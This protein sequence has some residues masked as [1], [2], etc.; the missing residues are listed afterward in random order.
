MQGIGGPGTLETKL[1]REVAARHGIVCPYAAD[2]HAEWNHCQ[3]TRIKIIL[4]D[5]PLRE[6]ITA[7]GP[8]SLEDMF[9]VG[10]ALIEDV[11]ST[12]AFAA[13]DLS[14]LAIAAAEEINAIR[15]GQRMVAINVKILTN[16]PE[17]KSKEPSL[18]AMRARGK[19]KTGKYGGATSRNSCRS[20]LR[21]SRQ[22]VRKAAHR[23]PT[24]RRTGRHRHS[25]HDMRAERFA[26]LHARVWN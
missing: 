10:N 18:A 8:V 3:P 13:A 7:E 19:L 4:P 11:E 14:L 6:R 17:A 15:L 25:A 22:R 23:A 9:E 26:A 1:W 5:H 12:E 16:V 20:C 24:R 21:R 2:N